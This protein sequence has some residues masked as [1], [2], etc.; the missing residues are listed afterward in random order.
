MKLVCIQPL[1]PECI[2]EAAAYSHVFFAEEGI[3]RGGIGE[4]FFAQLNNY[5]FKGVFRLRGVED[6]VE[7]ATVAQSLKKLGLDRESLLQ[8]ILEEKEKQ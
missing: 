4:E 3:R 1:N 2:R 7:H 8:W 5:G 6:F